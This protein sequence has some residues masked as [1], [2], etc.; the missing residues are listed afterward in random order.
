MDGGNCNQRH[1]RNKLNKHCIEM[2]V[3]KMILASDAHSHGSMFYHHFYI[4]VLV[5]TITFHLVT[6]K[7]Y[8]SHHLTSGSGSARILM[9]KNVFPPFWAFLLLRSDIHLGTLSSS[10]A[11]NNRC[12]I[13]PFFYI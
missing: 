11:K 6:R 3:T 10:S 1:T 13:I 9:L 8:N 7:S 12:N 4:T 2:L 5:M